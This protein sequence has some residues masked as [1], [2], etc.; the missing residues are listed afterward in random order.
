MTKGTDQQKLAVNSGVWPLYR[1]NPLSKAEGK[2]PLTLDSKEPSVDVADYIYNE[3]RY[4]SLKQSNP[5]RAEKLLNQLKEG[6]D[7]QYKRYK[8]LSEQPF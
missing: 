1:Y 8:A 3:V 2:N 6:V 4:R 5:E 7:Y